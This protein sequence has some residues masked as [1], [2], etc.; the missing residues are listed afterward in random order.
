MI[1]PALNTENKNERYANCFSNYKTMEYSLVRGKKQN[2]TKNPVYLRW[3]KLE[4]KEGGRSDGMSEKVL[5]MWK[6]SFLGRRAITI[7]SIPK[8]KRA[9]SKLTEKDRN[10]TVILGSMAE[11]TAQWSKVLVLHTHQFFYVPSNSSG[12]LFSSNQESHFLRLYLQFNKIIA[13]KRTVKDSSSIFLHKFM[14]LF[15]IIF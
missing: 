3:L 8:S 13:T 7:M 6:C 1:F 10:S 2:K 9:K 14:R 11:S 12:K 15:H 5:T 4:G